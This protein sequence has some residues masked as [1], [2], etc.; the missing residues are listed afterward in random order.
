M[1]SRRGHGTPGKAVVEAIGL[2]YPY[3]NNQPGAVICAGLFYV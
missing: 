3:K 1:L 2:D